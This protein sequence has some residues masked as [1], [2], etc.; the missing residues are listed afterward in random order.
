MEDLCARY[1]AHQTK[2]ATLP[3]ARP[4]EPVLHTLPA[5]GFRMSFRAAVIIPHYNDAE[6]LKICLTVLVPQLAAHPE[7]EAVVADNN[8]PVD[9]APLLAGFPGIQLL[10]EPTKGAAAARNCGVRGTTAPYLFFLD[11][12][13]VPAPDWLETALHLAGSAA[14]IGGEIGT[15]DET[16]APR[17]GA[18][19]FE[20]VFAFNQKSY[21]ERKGFSVTANLLTSRPVFANVG[22]FVVGVSEDLDWCQRAIG[23]GHDIVYA[24]SLRVSHPTRSGWAALR[25]KWQRLTEESFQLHRTNGGGRGAWA[26]RAIAVIGSGPV[27]A[28]A[29]WRS[30]RLSGV[31]ERLLGTATLVRLRLVRGAWML[32][33]AITCPPSAVS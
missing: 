8:S 27:H 4:P 21:V 18:E 7:V 9:L 28:L 23:K 32:R 3:L 24:D 12:D 14:V 25:R 2:H 19:A 26:L 5:K 13:C 17:S 15:F 30:P 29:I 22:N 6:R 31:S 11:A 16:P 33:Q 20:A 10:T 1:P